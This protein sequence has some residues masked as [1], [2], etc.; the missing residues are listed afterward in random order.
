MTARE[1][2]ESAWEQ[3][4]HGWY[5][6][7]EPAP[8]QIRG[9]TGLAAYLIVEA[10]TEAEAWDEALR[11]TLERKEEVRCLEEEIECLYSCVPM[12][13]GIPHSLIGRTITR[14]TQLLEIARRGFK[15]KG[16]KQ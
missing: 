4:V 5:I 1:R 12:R 16:S 8:Y 7:Y 2:V 14:L 3:V 13:I 11:I 15:T 9:G 6:V 10:P